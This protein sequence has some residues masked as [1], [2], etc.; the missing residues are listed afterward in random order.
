MTKLLWLHNHDYITLTT[1]YMTM[2][3]WLRLH[4][5]DYDYWTTWL[6]VYDYMSKTKRLHDYDD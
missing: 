3:I 4:D 2:T 1:D 6:P 5:Y